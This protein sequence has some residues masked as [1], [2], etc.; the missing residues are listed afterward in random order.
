MNIQQYVKVILSKS[1]ETQPIELVYQGM[2]LY[3]GELDYFYSNRVEEGIIIFWDEDKLIVS[4]V[5]HK[6]EKNC[7]IC[8]LEHR[9]KFKIDDSIGRDG[10]TIEIEDNNL[11]EE[12]FLY[13]ISNLIQVKSQPPLFDYFIIEDWKI[14]KCQFF[15]IANCD[16]CISNRESVEEIL[17]TGNS[18]CQASSLR[19]KLG[20]Y[21]AYI[22]LGNSDT[23]IF[24]RELTTLLDNGVTVELQYSLS[25]NE[26]ISGIGIDKSYKRAKAKAFLEAME[27]Y[28]GITSKGQKRYWFSIE[29][30]RGKSI[31]FLNPND[32]F[33]EL[34]K[35]EVASTNKFF[36][37]PAY[38]YQSNDY[39]L[40]PEDFII[41]KTERTPESK[42]LM[43]MSSNGHAIGNS[44][45][46]AV[47]FSLFE[48]YERDHFL[49]HWYEKQ[50]PQEINQ[51]SILDEDIHHY[52]SMIKNLGYEVSIYQMLSS[53][54]ISIY[55][56]I[57][58]GKN[59]SKFA[60]YS[61]AGAHLFGKT[62]II[63]ALKELY[64]ALYIYDEDVEHIKENGRQMQA[65]DV[66]TVADHA[67]YYSIEDRSIQFNFLKGVEV[68]DFEVKDDYSIELDSYYSDLLEF[69]NKLF[70]NFY[71]VDNTPKGLK[72]IGL[73]EVKVFVPG[74]QDMNFGYANQYINHQRIHLDGNQEVPIHPFP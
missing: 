36:W 62:A 11:F 41:Y 73:C 9:R 34:E 61:T 46:E 68:I 72:E 27:R 29:D 15:R 56:T 40:I 3:F 37:L 65:Q 14:S 16:T 58:R 35:E 59:G 21:S 17:A 19:E 23:G 10:D 67:I 45:K 8:F 28:S 43:N 39:A 69:T 52:L 50:P 55:W 47:I 49:V 33:L 20:D 4:P 25:N 66:K 60:T 12:K 51:D 48:M 74:M 32:Y 1:C 26:I 7:S 70:G 5:F 44:Y 30:L 13:V 38:N 53:K 2:R 63:S 6:K 71:I 57:A 54:V 22:Q 18:R 24:N 42:K 64:F 31:D